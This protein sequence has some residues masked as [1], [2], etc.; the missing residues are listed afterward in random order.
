MSL[1]RELNRLGV[2]R[3][4]DDALAIR[5]RILSAFER[6][7]MEPDPAAQAA[8]LTFAILLIGRK[9]FGWRGQRATHMLYAGALLLLLAYV[10]SRFV[11]EVILQR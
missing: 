6:A 1:L 11:I 7:E 3:T 5:R 4:L 2:L 9:K 10:G 8:W